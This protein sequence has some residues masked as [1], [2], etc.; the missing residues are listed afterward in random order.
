M[1]G[2]SRT[3]RAEAKYN[4]VTEFPHL[5]LHS[6]AATGNVGLVKYALDHGQ[7]INS[8]LDGVLPLHAA[9]SGGNDIVVR[10]LIEKGADVNAPRLP[11]RFSSD[12]NGDASAPIV[13]G[14][15]STPLHFACANGHTNI[16]LTLLLH[17]AHPDR[18]DKHGVTPEMVARQNGWVTCG[19]L[20]KQ[21]S[22][23][24]D[25]DLRE[26][27]VNSVGNEEP[28]DRHHFCAASDCQT[29][30]MSARL[31]VKRSIDNALTILRP[32]LSQ[33][34]SVS[35][36]QEGSE[37]GESPLPKAD[38]LIN[39][40]KSGAQEGYPP[41]RP[42]LPH[43][44]D[45]LHGPQSLHTHSQS[46]LTHP[47]RTSG[48][49]STGR[50]KSAGTDAEQSPSSSH[51]LKGKISLLSIF[52][53]SISDSPGTPESF[54]GY[55][56]SN[57]AMTSQSASPAPDQRR[58]FTARSSSHSRVSASPDKP[59]ADVGPVGKFRNRLCSESQSN[60][61]ARLGRAVAL[62]HALS[63]DHMRSRSSSGAGINDSGDI[64]TSLPSFPRGPP[65]RPGIL[66]PHHRS[67]SS[68]QSQADSYRASPNS[69][70]SL[71]ALRFDS[72]STTASNHSRGNSRRR[73]ASRSPAGGIRRSDSIGSVL[74]DGVS[75]NL[76]RGGYTLAPFLTAEPEDVRG[77]D[78]EKEDEEQY[79]EPIRSKGLDRNPRLT[80]LR[81][82]EPLVLSLDSLSPLPSPDM[83]KSGFECPFSIN[84][85][86]PVDSDPTPHPDASGIH[87]TEQRLRGD[88]V[89]STS[90]SGSVNPPTSSSGY[91]T[92]P[93]LS[94]SPLPGPRILSP[95]SIASE[96][97]ASINVPTDVLDKDGDEVA[98]PLTED[99]ETPFTSRGP[100]AP[101][102]I[103]IRSISSHAQAEALVQRAQK[104]IL[105][106]DDLVSDLQSLGGIVGS[107]RSP[108]S[109]KLAAY[110]ETLAIE[111][112]FK[113]EE[114]EKLRTPSTIPST[115]LS[116]D[117][118]FETMQGNHLDGA[119]SSSTS[120]GLDR[121][122]SLE[123][124]SDRSR[125][126]RSRRVKRPHTSGGTPSSEILFSSPINGTSTSAHRQSTSP[127]ITLTTSP[128]ES[129]LLSGD[130]T[131]SIT[132]P[133]TMHLHAK[134]ESRA[135][136]R[137]RMVRSRT[138]DPGYE[139][140]HPTTSYP[141]ETIPLSRVSTAPEHDFMPSMS[142]QER[143][144]ARAN[145]LV[146]M[147]FSSQDWQNATS[148][149]SRTQTGHKHR[150]GGIR[151]FVQNLKSKS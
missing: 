78:M 102:D 148:S 54:S 1:P 21:W 136:S 60:D 32:S 59:S 5:G 86:P 25:R 4:V 43:V 27:E 56:S 95:P 22:Q 73:H 51:K 3:Q 67:S 44:F 127:Q 77:E 65:V 7:P 39:Q 97:I 83:P 137:P 36:A 105:E 19:D 50:P 10:L 52:K 125:S 142:T 71:R 2:V 94:I 124:R 110:G 132:P 85:P 104:S 8:V 126:V 92:T 118:G 116:L 147:G 106:M 80:E 87:G 61:P 108:L 120:K 42:S 47:F 23:D 99:V 121:K 89:S 113:K 24:K 13:G 16:V 82:Q 139:S 129:S 48:G 75:S 28:E 114:Q 72:S 150:F 90:T 146:K 57:S 122:Y 68:G 79:G 38:T 62:H 143:Q 123:E 37:P 138:P 93:S 145:K 130:R 34:P 26:R 40:P 35:P 31:R 33:A 9:C 58:E 66:L 11:R 17:G 98:E 64:G 12:R 112:K 18:P 133:K 111:R 69:Q 115:S 134:S 144:V 117:R 14:S 119:S 131:A 88:S 151:T 109:A 20:L 29:C 100:R 45:S 74:S 107:G 30:G 46:S 140:V 96:T 84:S 70:P 149:Y 63:N 128:S 49:T 41:R 101:L 6:A 15:G 103:D 141:V 135:R 55:S 53:K 81:L 76:D 91:V